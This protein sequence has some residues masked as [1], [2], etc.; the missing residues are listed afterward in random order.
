[1]NNDNMSVTPAQLEAGRMLFAGEINF[2]LSVVDMQGLPQTDLPEVCFAGRSNVGKSSLINAVCG[3][4]NLARTSNTPGRTREL[5]Y[6]NLADRLHMIDLPGY[7]F[8]R[9]PKEVIARWTRLMNMFLQ[10]R[11]NLRRVFLLIDARHGL[12]DTDKQIMDV[13]DEGAISYQ[14][15]L[16][17]SDKPKKTALEQVLTH[18]QDSI[19]L[20]PAAYPEIL[21]SSSHNKQG[22]DTI[23][24][25]IAD[26]ANL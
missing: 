24:A 15:V 21:F 4:K 19:A 1:M 16:T 13:L 10:T 12:K 5:N 20:R 23:R 6:F 17:K 22:I 18:T 14:I 3:R 11:A 7:G 25:R 9:A 8:A 2:M 26:L